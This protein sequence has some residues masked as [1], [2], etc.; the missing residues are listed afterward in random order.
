MK[1]L[2]I[3]KSVLH[4]L[5]TW[6]SEDVNMAGYK[7]IEDLT[8]D[9]MFEAYGKD[10]KEVFQNA[11]MALSSVICKIDRIRPRKPVEIRANGDGAKEL[12]FNWLQELIA[13]VDVH[14]MFFSKFEIAEIDEHH[15]K[16]KIWGEGIRPE[17]GNTVVKA[18]TYYKFR[19]E[20]KPNGYAARVAL[21]I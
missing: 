13:S 11:A 2:N 15:M 19:F 5:L 10:L 4:N 6:E 1:R 17:N 14:G 3:I 20:K 18:V 21:D 8:S 7:F 9:V 16:A 12:M